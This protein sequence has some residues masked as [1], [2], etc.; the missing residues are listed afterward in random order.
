MPC[1]GLSPSTKPYGVP[2]AVAAVRAGHKIVRVTYSEEY[3]MTGRVSAV[4][5]ILGRW[6]LHA[7][8][9][10]DDRIGADG[11]APGTLLELTRETSSAG[12][13]T[14]RAS[15]YEKP[16]DATELH[17]CLF[18][19]AASR[20]RGRLAHRSQ[21]CGQEAQNLGDG[22]RQAGRWVV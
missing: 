18:G 8:H 10:P 1:S 6:A 16:D 3:A 12:C 15:A 14:R 21:R 19:T 4:A 20:G 17:R 13:T 5:R 7:D 11:P 9:V 22:N 2:E